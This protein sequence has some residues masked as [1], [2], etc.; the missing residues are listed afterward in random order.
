MEEIVN[1]VLGIR[2]SFNELRIMT[3][4]FNDDNTLVKTQDYDLYRATIAPQSEAAEIQHVTVKIWNSSFK[5]ERFREEINILGHPRVINCRN[6]ATIM[7]YCCEGENV[8]TVYKLQSVDTLENLLDKDEFVWRDRMIAALGI[9]HIFRFIDVKRTSPLIHST[10]PSYTILD[11]ESNPV[12]CDVRV[13]MGGV[14]L[15]DEVVEGSCVRN[16]ACF[17]GE[18]KN[19]VLFILAPHLNRLRAETAKGVYAVF[20]PDCLVSRVD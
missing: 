2:F 3:D 11:Q 9:A 19:I 14:A 20:L 10:L 17:F 8:A 16:D 13:L 1:E 12:L 6:I 7:G 18:D 4:E 15:L 5:L